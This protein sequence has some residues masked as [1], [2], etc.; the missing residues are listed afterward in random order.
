[1]DLAE[2]L[3]LSSRND[4]AREALRHAFGWYESKGNVIMVGTVEAL[5]YQPAL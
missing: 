5:L 3:R 1:M 4:D 2:V